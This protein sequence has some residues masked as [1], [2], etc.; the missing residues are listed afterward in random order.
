MLV[1][2]SDWEKSLDKIFQG[3]LV[4]NVQKFPE[5]RVYLLPILS[6]GAVT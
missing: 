1:L 2:D 4:Q 5:N 3:I 6:F